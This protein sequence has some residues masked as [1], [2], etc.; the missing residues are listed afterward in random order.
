MVVLGHYV[1]TVKSTG[2]QFE[3]DW[4]HIFTVRE[5]KVV[6]FREFFDSHIAEAAYQS[7]Q[8]GMVRR[9]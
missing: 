7:Q 6:N 5:G 3:S 9:G 1:W 2:A 4:T 8:I